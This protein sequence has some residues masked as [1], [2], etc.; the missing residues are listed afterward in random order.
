MRA[1]GAAP[2]SY[3]DMADAYPGLFPNP[4]A[5]PRRPPGPKPCENAYREIPDSVFTVSIRY[6]RGS[7]RGPAGR[8]FYLPARVD[9][10][11]W[12]TERLGDVKLCGEPV[13]VQPEDAGPMLP[14]PSPPT[15]LSPMSS[16]SRSLPSSRSL[17][18][19]WPPS[20]SSGYAS[21]TNGWPGGS[22]VR[23]S[24]RAARQSPARYQA[25]PW[26]RRRSRILSWFRYKP[27]RSL[28]KS[29]WRR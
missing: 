13:P 3:R 24:R 25:T 16:P 12:L 9:P 27:H 26:E 18:P 2:L 23:C 29:V 4:R 22:P 20:T 10:L 8:L 11:A 5:R 28:D 15:I 1:R 6:R 14:R 17:W 7:S 21:T 19:Q